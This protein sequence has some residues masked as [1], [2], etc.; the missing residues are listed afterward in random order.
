MEVACGWG[1]RTLLEGLE[2]R[3]VER[4]ESLVEVAESLEALSSCLVELE[5]LPGFDGCAALDPATQ[6]RTQPGELQEVVAGSID[7]LV[8]IAHEIEKV[9]GIAGA[10]H[11]DAHAPAASRLGSPDELAVVR[12]GHEDAAFETRGGCEADVFSRPR[13]GRAQE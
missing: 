2:V 7:A 5:L 3:E 10:G 13:I 9:L 6:S 1:R 12:S 4:P 11:G 8:G